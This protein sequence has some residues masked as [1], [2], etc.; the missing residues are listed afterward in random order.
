MT[1]PLQNRAHR[2]VV[3]AT[4][5]DLERLESLRTLIAHD[6]LFSRHPVHEAELF[7]AALAVAAAQLGT[8]IA[9]DGPGTLA[10]FLLEHITAEREQSQQVHAVK[11]QQA[12]RK[13][14]GRRAPDRLTEQP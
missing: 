5:A 1:P 10:T 11:M 13:T 12:Q 4:D 14:R 8:G 3:N 6:P 9:R 2:K 7:R